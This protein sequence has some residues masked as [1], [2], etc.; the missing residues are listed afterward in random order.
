MATTTKT[1]PTNTHANVAGLV[2][3]YAGF[4]M[5]QTL[6]GRVMAITDVRGHP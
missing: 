2:K 6:S 1:A 5:C 3:K 4:I